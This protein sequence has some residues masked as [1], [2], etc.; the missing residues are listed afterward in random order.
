MEEQNTQQPSINPQ[1]STPQGVSGGQPKSLVYVL[2]AALVIALGALG[3][4]FW[5]N[6]QSASNSIL[7]PIPTQ[8]PIASQSPI[9]TQTPTPTS[10]SDPAAGWKMSSNKLFSIKYPSYF[11]VSLDKCSVNPDIKS[12]WWCMLQ[13]GGTNFSFSMEANNPGFDGPIMTNVKESQIIIDGIIT[14]YKI[15]DDGDSKSV[16]IFFNQGGNG[17]F[18]F[19]SFPNDKNVEMNNSL[20]KQILSTFKF[21]K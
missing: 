18:I 16:A 19:S 5:Q 6:Q 3:Y 2:S 15:G 1:P 4:M 12:L 13:L 7:T 14:N 17:Y 11:Q 21:N 10:S 8:T 9:P 20:V